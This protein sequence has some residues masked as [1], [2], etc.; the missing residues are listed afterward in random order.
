M[1]LDVKS[2]Y[3][4][5]ASGFGTFQ[6]PSTGVRTNLMMANRAEADRCP[7]QEPQKGGKVQPVV[8][9]QWQLKTNLVKKF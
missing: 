8:W 1:S 5:A 4:A 2:L 3:T 6:Q 7:P 9:Q